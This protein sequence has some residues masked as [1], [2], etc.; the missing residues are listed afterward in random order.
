MKRVMIF[1][2]LILPSSFWAQ[3]SWLTIN[4][5]T[6]NDLTCV[7]FVRGTDIVLAGG[8][9]ATLLK[10]L[11]AGLTWQTVNLPNNNMLVLSIAATHPDT[12]VIVTSSSASPFSNNAVWESTDA[13]QS[14][15]D[16]SNVASQCFPVEVTTRGHEFVITDAGCFASPYFIRYRDGQLLN[17]TFT[18]GFFMGMVPAKTVFPSSDTGYA[19][20]RSSGLISKSTDGGNTWLPIF[21]GDSTAEFYDVYF[22]DNLHGFVV[23]KD[24]SQLAWAPNI[25]FETLDG[26]LTWTVAYG[27][28]FVTPSLRAID[29]LGGNQT[30]AI[31][32]FDQNQP[33]SN[34]YIMTYA[35]AFNTWVSD[36]DIPFTNNYYFHDIDHDDNGCFIIVGN[37]GLILRRC[38]VFSATNSAAAIRPSK[39]FPNPSIGQLQLEQYEQKLYP[40]TVQVINIQGIILKE[41]SYEEATTHSIHLDKS[42][43]YCLNVYSAGRLVQQHKCIVQE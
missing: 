43:V 15:H 42:G 11:D 38:D 20:S 9:N 39:I 22:E 23:G 25:I 31:G 14:W 18:N 28:L 10:S 33:A 17:N 16:I 40:I 19:V 12:I 2:A 37:D 36:S 6:S 35:P 21:Y 1:L 4:S 29:G 26:G 3:V 7:H 13:G 27:S 5:N 30:I 24:T 41:Y 32:S 8:D 34:A